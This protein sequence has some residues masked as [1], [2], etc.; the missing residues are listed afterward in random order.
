M[1]RRLILLG[2]LLAGQGCEGPEGAREVPLSKTRPA[3]PTADAGA[4]TKPPRA[5]AT[6]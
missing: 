6:H 3:A 4:P 1:F 2:L 5:I